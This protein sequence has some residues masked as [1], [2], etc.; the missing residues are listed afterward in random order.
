[1]ESIVNRL[2]DV[3]GFIQKEH[4]RVAAAAC[5]ATEAADKIEQQSAQIERMR[6][7]LES[8]NQTLRLHM[9]EL[10]AQEMRALKAAFKWILSIGNPEKES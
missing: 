7:V 1:M 5:L 9:G 10:S 2:R 4:G 6:T 8:D 3:A